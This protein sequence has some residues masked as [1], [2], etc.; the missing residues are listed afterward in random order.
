MQTILLIGVTRKLYNAANRP[1]K[2][3]IIKNAD[4]VFND[5]E[6]EKEVIELSLDWFKKYLR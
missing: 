1:K 6:H 5:T 2:I 3:K 4:H